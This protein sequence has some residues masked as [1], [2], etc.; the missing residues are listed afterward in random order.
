[1]LVLSRKKGEQIRIGEDIVI[2]I[3]R[4]SGNRVSLGIEAPAKCRITRGELMTLLN[5]LSTSADEMPV[6]PKKTLNP[7]ARPT[8]NTSPTVGENRIAPHLPAVLRM[9]K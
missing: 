4:L 8:R 2:T 6:A 5:E 7:T 3:Q 9:P 1:M